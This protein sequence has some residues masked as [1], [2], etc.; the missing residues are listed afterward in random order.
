MAALRN[1]RKLAAV[2]KEIPEISRNSQSQNTFDPGVTQEYI[3]QVSEEIEWRV[4]KK[5]SEEFSRLESRIW[6]L[7]L[8]L[9]NFF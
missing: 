2:S 8:N 9:M 5:L 1:K 6:V 3:S 4:T 7:C